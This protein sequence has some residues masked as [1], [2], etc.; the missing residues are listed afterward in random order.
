M[1]CRINQIIMTTGSPAQAQPIIRPMDEADLAAAL[2]LWGKTDGVE[3]AEGD[4]AAELA[5][6]LLRNPGASQ[7]ATQDGVLIGAVLAGH[8]GRRGL[9]YHLA[10]APGHR[11]RFIG[12]SLVSKSLAALKLQGI[13]RALILVASDNPGGR[14]FWERSGWQIMNFA[15]TLGIDLSERDSSPN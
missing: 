8:D 14:N 11:G 15:H 13:R 4:S 1:L 6:Y 2:R 5:L 12:R 7:V 3:V 9:I 10:V